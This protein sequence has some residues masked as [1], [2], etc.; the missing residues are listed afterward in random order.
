MGKGRLPG[1]S[2]ASPERAPPG[3]FAALF[4]CIHS[5]IDPIVCNGTLA[6][7]SN[8]YAVKRGQCMGPCVYT[9]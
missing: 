2:L 7:E 1:P 9:I 8:D 5:V 3:L 4:N 6:G